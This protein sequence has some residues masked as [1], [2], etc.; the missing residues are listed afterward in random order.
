MNFELVSVHAEKWGHKHIWK[1]IEAKLKHVKF[2]LMLHSSLRNPFWL[3]FIELPITDLGYVR[4]NRLEE[5]E[6]ENWCDNFSFSFPDRSFAESDTVAE[7]SFDVGN[8]NVGFREEEDFIHG[9]KLPD[10]IGVD[11][12]DCDMVDNV[13]ED[14]IISLVHV[15]IKIERVPMFGKAVLVAQLEWDAEGLEGKFKD[16]IA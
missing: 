5:I 3:Y 11:K 15:F 9:E 7:E 12:V 16:S 6:G 8:V 4:N 2:D 14:K 10:H 13:M 1:N